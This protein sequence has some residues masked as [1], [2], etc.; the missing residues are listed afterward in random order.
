MKPES[1]AW[2]QLEKHAAAQL[3]P[4]F[5]DRVMRQARGPTA[6]AWNEL[7]ARAAALVRPGFAERVLRAV[8]AEIPSFSGQL[9]LSAATAAVCLF[10]VLYLHHRSTR[11]EN[12]RNLAYWQ[13]LDDDARDLG[14]NP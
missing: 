8:R 13:Q 11:L 2:R 5:A 10:T 4:G 14:L 1:P 6:A 12:E 3:R 7:Q 9:A